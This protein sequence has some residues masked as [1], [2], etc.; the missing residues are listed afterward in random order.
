MPRRRGAHRQ[1]DLRRKE[2][3]DLRA[4]ELDLACADAALPSEAL[5]PRVAAQ[6]GDD[7]GEV[8][9]AEAMAAEMANLEA[10][11]EL[12]VNGKFQKTEKHK[13]RRCCRSIGLWGLYKVMRQ[14]RKNRLDMSARL[15]LGSP[16]LPE[17]QV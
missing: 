17:G 12:A 14:G 13:I 15:K 3:A 5:G 10:M 6:E 4:G 8:A 2:D 7:P 16:D 11:R 9:A 1:G